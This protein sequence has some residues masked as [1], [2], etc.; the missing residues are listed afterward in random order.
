M[1]I[2][3]VHITSLLPTQVCYTVLKAT[4][5]AAGSQ[6]A[7]RMEVDSY[8]LRDQF[9]TT[10]FIIDNLIPIT[11]HHVRALILNTHV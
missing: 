2:I 9:Y 6:L 10:F 4:S 11:H 8:L 3:K 1:L 7:I 5:V